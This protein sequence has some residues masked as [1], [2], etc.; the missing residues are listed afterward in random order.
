[1]AARPGWGGWVPREEKYNSF[2]MLNT[3]NI[4]MNAKHKSS[5]GDVQSYLLTWQCCLAGNLRLPTATALPSLAKKKYIQIAQR[6][7]L[8]DVRI[9][10]A[11][12]L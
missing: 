7:T 11:I 6:S 12:L 8:A 9:T 3:L 1:M 4:T 10:W 2:K 5:I